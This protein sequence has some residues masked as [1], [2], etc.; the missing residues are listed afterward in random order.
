[1]QCFN[2]IRLK[3]EKKGCFRDVPCGR[4]PACH[5]NRRNGWKLR[6]KNER[7]RF[8]HTYFATLTYDPEFVPVLEAHEIY[9]IIHPVPVVS[10]RDIQ[11]FLKRLRSRLTSEVRYYGVSEY[12]PTTYRPHYHIIFF[13][14]V[15]ET[16]F[17]NAVDLSWSDSKRLSDGST[18]YTSMGFIKVDDIDHGTISAKYNWVKGKNVGDRRINYLTKYVSMK[19][20]LPSMLREVAPPFVFCS[21]HLGD[22]FL[23]DYIVSYYRHCPIKSKLTVRFDGDT[24]YMPR[25]YSERL[26]SKLEKE[27][28][29]EFCRNEALKKY[30]NMTDDEFELEI[31]NDYWQK[32]RYH[33]TYESNFYKGR[34]I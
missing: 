17:R 2:P 18:E 10:R 15:P 23:S 11:L 34:D 14:D 4:C 26:Y 22:N 20:V 32:I 5:S 6:L 27:A 9:N 24:Y 30:R 29:V 33:A 19:T 28:Y 12:G 25:Y 13:T 1:M 31:E 21:K 16:D 3:D 8:A 7:K